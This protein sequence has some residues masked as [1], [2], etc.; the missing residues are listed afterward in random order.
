MFDSEGVREYWR[1]QMKR[2]SNPCHYHN[3]WQDRYA[4]EVRTNAFKNSDFTKMKEIVDVGCGIGEYTVEI[5]KLTSAH[6]SAFDFPFN[7][8]VALERYGTHP[9]ISFYPNSVPHESIERAIRVADCVITTTVY[10]H[11]SE[12]ARKAFFAY[13]SR[14]KPRGKIMLLEYVPLEIPDF[15]KSLSYKQIETLSAIENRFNASGFRLIEVRHVNF[16]DSFLFFYLGK[17]AVVYAITKLTEHLLRLV[18]YQKSKYKLLVF[19]RNS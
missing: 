4:F 17:N 11:F 13:I 8:E 3:E 9:H 19:E 5:A 18:G 7:I 1:Q 14:M 16:I 12:E 15:Q 6:F 2:G 10:V